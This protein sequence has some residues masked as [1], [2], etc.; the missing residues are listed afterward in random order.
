MRE[1]LTDEE[2]LEELD[3]ERF[4][5]PLAG[6]RSRIAESPIYQAVAPVG[7]AIA[8]VGAEVPGF[9]YRRAMD[10]VGTAGQA[11][12]GMGETI[13]TGVAGGLRLAGLDEAAEG[14]TSELERQAEPGRPRNVDEMVVRGAGMMVPY[15]AGPAAVANRGPGAPAAAAAATDLLVAAGSEEMS[16]AGMLE[17][18]PEDSRIRRAGEA[19]TEG[20]GF[21]S[22]EEVAASPWKRGV[23]EAALFAVPDVIAGAPAAYRGLRGM[24]EAGHVVTPGGARTPERVPGEIETGMPGPWHSRLR[25]AIE[26]APQD[27]A[28]PEQWLGM[29]KKSPSGVGSDELEFTGFQQAL[30]EAEGPLAREEVM[31]IAASRPLRITETVRRGR[32]PNQ[33][34]WNQSATIDG[35]MSDAGVVNRWEH[36]DRP[37]QIYEMDDGT[38]TLDVYGDAVHGLNSFEEAADRAGYVDA[39]M[40]RDASYGEYTVNRRGREPDAKYREILVQ[41]DR[42]RDTSGYSAEKVSSVRG[43]FWRIVNGEGVEVGRG[44]G[45]TADE[46]LTQWGKA[47]QRQH[48]GTHFRE[49]DIIG[50]IR[51]TDEVGDDGV[52]E[53]R[54]R[55]AQSDLHQEGRRTGYRDEEAAARLREEIEAGSRRYFELEKGDP[56]RA[57]LD[58]DLAEKRQR[59]REMNSGIPDA[60]Y[61][62]DWPAVLVRRSL[63]EG[64]EGGYGRVVFPT[65]D[66]QLY[67]YGTQ[68]VTWKQRPDGAFDVVVKPQVGGASGGIAD[69]GE[70]AVARGI[71]S[72]PTGRVES[73]G[74]LRRMIADAGSDAEFPDG[75]AEKL[76]DR[77]QKEAEGSSRPRAEGMKYFY[78]ERIVPREIEREAKRLGLKVTRVPNR[79]TAEIK[80]TDFGVFDPVDG[81]EFFRV[82]TEKEA[83]DFRSMLGLPEGYEWKSR[84]RPDLGTGRTEQVVVDADGVEVGAAAASPGR[85]LSNAKTD[86][87]FARAYEELYRPVT[88]KYGDL[89]EA[90]GRLDYAQTRRLGDHIAVEITPQAR[91][92]VAR[93]GMRLGATPGVMARGL[94]GALGGGAAGAAGDDENRLRGALGGAALGLAGGLAPE[95][96]GKLRGM[97]EQGHLVAAVRNPDTGV[98][99][100][101]ATHPTILN[102]DGFEGVEFGVLETKQ[103]GEPFFVTHENVSEGVHG[104]FRAVPPELHRELTERIEVALKGGKSGDLIVDLVNPDARFERILGVGVYDGKG[105]PNVILKFDLDTIS[106]E[107]IRLVMRIRGM[108]MGQDAEA[109]FM[110]LGRQFATFD[111]AVNGVGEG[112]VFGIVLRGDTDEL[113]KRLDAHGVGA[114]ITDD[115]AYVVDF[116]GLG[117]EELNRRLTKAVG[118]L[119]VEVHADAFEGEYLARSAYADAGRLSPED[120]RALARILEERIVPAYRGFAQG[121]GL[122]AAADLGA[123]GELVRGLRAHADPSAGQWWT[124]GGRQALE[125]APATARSTDLVPRIEVDD[126]VAEIAAQALVKRG[127]VNKRAIAALAGGD[128]GLAKQAVKFIEKRLGEMSKDLP[129]P[130]P[131]RLHELLKKGAGAG[132]F[133]RGVREAV[134]SVLGP[135]DAD[136]FLRF[137]AAT[138]SGTDAATSNIGF[139][140]KAFGQWKLGLEFTGYLRGT[141]PQMLR[142]A[143]SGEVFGARK[144]QQYY[145]ALLGDPDAYVHDMWMGRLFGFGEQA[146]DSQYRYA[147]Q[148]VRRVAGEAGISVAEA[149]EALWSGM[150]RWW[151]EAGLG[152]VT[153]VEDY[154]ALLRRVLSEGSEGSKPWSDPSIVTRIGDPEVADEFIRVVEEDLARYE[155]TY[156]RK[157]GYSDLLLVRALVTAGGA[158]VGAMADEEN[159]L[160]GA[161][162]GAGVGAGVALGTATLPALRGMDSWGAVGGGSNVAEWW[163][164]ETGRPIADFTDLSAA[165]Q[166]AQVA[167]LRRAGTD[168]K[169]GGPG[170]IVGGE[171]GVGAPEYGPDFRVEGGTVTSTET[172]RFMPPERVLSGDDPASRSDAGFALRE[173]PRSLV[174]G[175]VGG[176]AGYASADDPDEKIVRAALGALGGMAAGPALRHGAPN[177]L[178]KGVNLMRAAMLSSPAT[179][180]RNMLGNTLQAVGDATSQTAAAMV[181]RIALS[182][183]T[184]ERVI[185]ALRLEDL[186]NASR[187]AATDGYD[188][189]M[190][191]WKEGASVE[192]LAKLDIEPVKFDNAFLAGA[193]EAVFRTMSATDRPFYHFAMGRSISEQTRLMAQELGGTADEIAAR[194]AQLRANPPDQ[195]VLFAAMDA[196]ESVFRDPGQLRNAVKELRNVA[197]GLGEP[198]EMMFDVI[199]PF[200]STPSN[201]A[202]RVL[203]YSPLGF[204][205]M[206]RSRTALQRLVE[207]NAAKVAFIPE[208]GEQAKRLEGVDEALESVKARDGMESLNQRALQRRAAK[209]GGRALVG[210]AALA[211]GWLL[212]DK[213]TRTYP[214]GDSTERN[215]L[216]LADEQTGSL[217]VN[218]RA[219]SIERLGPMATL[220]VMGAELRR[221]TEEG[222]SVGRTA[223]QL[224]EEVVGSSPYGDVRELGNMLVGQYPNETFGDR[225]EGLAVDRAGA[226]VPNVVGSATAAGDPVQRERRPGSIVDAVKA[227]V[228]GLRQT[229][230]ARIDALGREQ[231]R[232]PGG[233][234]GVME[235]LFNPLTSRQV[236]DDPLVLMLDELDV[237]LPDARASLAGLGLSRGT[238]EYEAVARIYG[239]KVH[240][241]IVGVMESGGQLTIAGE[242]THVSWDDASED[243]RR[244]LIENAAS[245]AK[246][247]LSRELRELRGGA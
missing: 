144:V 175:V 21:G 186:A 154:P 232:E 28:T 121:A 173:V 108:L 130:T 62:K 163:S 156:G 58:V 114:T 25:R 147:E 12:A 83:R 133:Y 38:F 1:G 146:S 245:A 218:G 116:D 176:S 191:A 47:V 106:R 27:K 50:S 223:Q 73:V 23:A 238:E 84:P 76:W 215:Q 161:A 94:G 235:R 202:T 131:E 79:D 187:K 113:A 188:E 201:I 15:L 115:A 36:S 95:V 123:L 30:L 153:D 70:E 126:P 24:G 183:I 180:M 68:L 198:A 230:P 169:L 210:S 205:D 178:R 157:A 125:G 55:E 237:S 140:A 151:Q 7:R 45:A 16:L 209:A 17:G 159:R 18:M 135:E 124:K 57:A 2:I 31:Q 167:Q 158:A 63:M 227:R 217:V 152:R 231:R 82:A 165:E 120:S 117:P 220:L 92:R 177:T 208:F 137:L 184:G 225:L 19:Y 69:I 193:T 37:L 119:D 3:R 4:G 110:P 52:R 87:D 239:E 51:V 174:G 194:A 148:V 6:I 185:G 20:V 103:H 240:A 216:Q 88:E 85:A 8:R 204:V 56:E 132:H 107:E 224:T 166:R 77:M 244:R 53:L 226:M 11:L 199:V 179:V 229:L 149:Q 80:T 32:P 171:R 213:I 35:D 97:G 43:D 206:A 59:L 128:E 96:F 196:A 243:E 48:R 65:A 219:Y 145:R 222:A 172:G 212:K 162:I 40:G 112:E 207:G 72:E 86:P 111:D 142:Q 5:G 247:R 168:A 197:K 181:D 214:R 129:L 136:M 160:R 139:A 164:K 190:K 101:G 29:I 67:Q 241:A 200:Q 46:A 127:P 13:T 49:P 105:R 44:R 195:V 71:I 34:G 26:E 155:E 203:Q 89:A 42:R 143:A 93:E 138:S 109:G 118:D 39:Q 150:K 81:Q 246:T 22:L 78:D 74:Q 102:L 242:R 14:L 233:A 90:S 170:T 211:L 182:G 192:E 134:E 141:V 66:E 234:F 228:P 64:I 98:T 75:F 9:V 60:P 33:E 236:E 10:P 221:R 100:I 189:M 104:V 61:K 41:F 99:A 122:D 91:E 54:V